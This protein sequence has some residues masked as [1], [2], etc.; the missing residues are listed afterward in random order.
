MIR[1][2]KHFSPFSGEVCGDVEDVGGGE[3]EAEADGFGGGEGG[4]AEGGGRGG[5]AGAEER[6]QRQAEHAEPGGCQL[7]F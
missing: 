3:R 4:R 1:H 6:R 5:R 2:S 7:Y